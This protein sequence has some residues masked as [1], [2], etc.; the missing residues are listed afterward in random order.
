MDDLLFIKG[1]TTEG[2]Q[3]ISKNIDVHQEQS[4]L[5]FNHYCTEELMF[6][7]N[8]DEVFDDLN[9]NLE[10]FWK[11]YDFNKNDRIFSDLI[12]PRMNDAILESIFERKQIDV[13]KLIVNHEHWMDENP[14]KCFISSRLNFKSF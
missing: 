5:Y 8:W 12:I 13:L 6:E 2:L 1:I 9:K 11:L 10:V 14:L 4:I 3:F 7:R